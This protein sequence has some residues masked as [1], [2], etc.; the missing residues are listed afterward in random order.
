MN[1]YVVLFLVAFGAVAEQR[2]LPNPEI[3]KWQAEAQARE[4]AINRRVEYQLE[5]T[6]AAQR[7]RQPKEPVRPAKSL[8]FRRRCEIGGGGGVEPPSEKIRTEETACVA[9]S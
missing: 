2:P 1:R 7:G 9:G 5:K 8:R 4:R 3:L 6:R